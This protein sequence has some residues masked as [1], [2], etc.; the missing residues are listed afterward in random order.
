MQGGPGRGLQPGQEAGEAGRLVV[1]EAVPAELRVGG[2]RLGGVQAG[3]GAG[4]LPVGVLRVDGALRRPG[5]PAEQLAGLPDQHA[6]PLLGGD[7]LFAAAGRAEPGDALLGADVVQAAEGGEDV[8]RVLRVVR[9]DRLGRVAAGEHRRQ[10]VGRP[11]A[12]AGGVAVP[13]R[14]AGQLREVRVPGRVDPPVGAE[15]ADQ[16]Q[17]V[18]DQ[19]DHRRV[20]AGALRGAGRA[21]VAAGQHHRRGGRGEQEERQEGHRPGGGQSQHPARR[22]PPPVRGRAGGPG[23]HGHQQQGY[24]PKRRHVS[25]HLH[26]EGGEQQADQ[27]GVGEGAGGPAGQSA[28][29]AEQRHRDRGQH[30]HQGDQQQDLGRV[31]AVEQEEVGA[32][33]EHVQQR[34][35]D[36]QADQGRHL[37]QPAQLAAPALVPPRGG[38][39]RVGGGGFSHPSPSGRACGCPRAVPGAR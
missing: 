7:R 19:H 10:R 4:L 17:L 21:A 26:G 31:G 35:G 24:A 25:A 32:A 12:D 13:G 38:R 34:L 9:G 8:V 6:E 1:V 27:P 29:R 22:P 14:A 39:W 11:P 23:Q 37:Q 28:E 2:H 18:E 33:A 36:H 16:R 3:L 5:D 20:H 15:Q 30:R